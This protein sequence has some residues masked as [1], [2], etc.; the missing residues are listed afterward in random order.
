M[1]FRPSQWWP[2]VVTDAVATFKAFLPA[3]KQWA[4][5]GFRRAFLI[6]VVKYGIDVFWLCF[7]NR[8]LGVSY[9]R[10]LSLMAWVPASFQYEWNADMRVF[11]RKCGYQYSRDGNAVGTRI[12][13]WFY[14]EMRDDTRVVLEEIEANAI[15]RVERHR[16]SQP[17]DIKS[18]ETALSNFK[19]F[20]MEE[21]MV[22]FKASELMS[23]EEGQP[24][25][26]KDDE[27][28]F[29]YGVVSG[30]INLFCEGIGNRGVDLL[31][32]AGPD[33]RSYTRDRPNINVNNFIVL[34]S[35]KIVFPYV[36]NL[37]R[38]IRE[39][40]KK[41][42]EVLSTI[43]IR[44]QKFAIG[45]N[46]LTGIAPRIHKQSYLDSNYTPIDIDPGVLELGTPIV[47]QAFE[48]LQSVF[49]LPVEDRRLCWVGVLDS[50]TVLLS[51]FKRV[52]WRE[53]VVGL[54][55]DLQFQV[56]DGAKALVVA[57]PD[58]VMRRKTDEGNG[59]LYAHLCL[60]G[61]LR[62]LLDSEDRNPG[63]SARYGI[64]EKGDW[65]GLMATYLDSPQVLRTVVCDRYTEIALVPRYVI[66]VITSAFREAA[67]YQCDYVAR[68]IHRGVKVF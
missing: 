10:E 33:K 31:K 60:S 29:F 32:V 52:G 27:Q 46:D 4:F 23:M 25:F 1:I 20:S 24:I 57:I 49:P 30:E 7:K 34:K 42:L 38:Y 21:I 8:K 61:R 48:G 16:L 51:R 22:F 66:S 62:F 40:K 26:G 41:M 67:G 6:F 18:V 3:L 47:N 14:G 53:A 35:C 15:K 68:C 44:Q 56:A 59:E 13:P 43:L 45:L 63:S 54:N 64:I 17:D 12:E 28:E 36:T 50:R 2:L 65:F 9:A 58:F 19:D 37:K 11:I 55:M 5:Y 39:D